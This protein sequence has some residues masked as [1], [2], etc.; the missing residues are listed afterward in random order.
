MYSEKRRVTDEIKKI[1]KCCFST[2]L[3]RSPKMSMSAQWQKTSRDSMGK[4]MKVQ[5]ADDVRVEKMLTI[6]LCITSKYE[7]LYV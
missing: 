1:N 5:S 6:N 7:L 2:W 3:L 4:L